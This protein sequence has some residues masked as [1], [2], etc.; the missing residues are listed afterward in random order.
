[1]TKFWLNYHASIFSAKAIA[2]L[3]A[4]DIISQSTEQDFLILSDS[5]S[6][7][8][9]V[10]NINLENPIV[11]EIL[12]RVHQQLHLDRRI[13][14]LWVPSHIGI[15]GN[16]AVDVIAKAG[17]SLPIPNAEIPHT[18]FKPIISSHV[19]NCWQLCWNSDTNNKL[20]RI[21]PVIKSF[22]SIVCHVE[23]KY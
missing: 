19:K 12:E 21:Q 6:C 15:A 16:T 17:V 9:T 11:V 5:M 4:L 10:E 7:V 23:T 1:M 14:F 8:N 22:I 2:I 20:F 18:D 3:L 13:T